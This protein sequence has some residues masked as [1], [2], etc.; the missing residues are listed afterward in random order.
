MAVLGLS[1]LVESRRGVPLGLS[2]GRDL[3]APSK[4]G[5]E[6]RRGEGVLVMDMSHY[7]YV[8]RMVRVRETGDR[9]VVK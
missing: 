2:S 8:V 7:R 9:P 3:V 5:G 4:K 1:P 6:G